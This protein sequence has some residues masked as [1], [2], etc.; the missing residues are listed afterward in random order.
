MAKQKNLLQEIESKMPQLS[1][2]QKLVAKFILDHYEKAAFST[3]LRM[4]QAVG[5]SESTVIR[6]SNS[7]GFEGYTELQKELQEL[8]K[9][10]LTTVQRIEVASDMLNG[11]DL[12]KSVLEADI[13]KIK[14]T[15]DTI[16]HEQ[17]DSAIKLLLEAKKIYIV[18]FRSSAPLGKFL[19]FYLNLILDN[20]IIIE[21]N[22]MG[23]VFEQIFKITP[24]DVMIGISYPRYSQRTLK[25][26]QYALNNG[27]KVISITDSQLSPLYNLGDAVLLAKSGMTFF[28][29]SLV[30]PLSIINAIIAAIGM[31]KKQQLSEK[32]EKLEEIW[33]EYN[34][35]QKDEE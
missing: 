8:I 11:E 35:Y 34:V 23:E 1:K 2:G 27:A 5:V 9:S 4:G 21:S 32:L 18:G 10:K 31:M 19:G 16:N 29:D 24:D 3:A 6:F 26:V 13:A 25:S 28:V 12:I 33:D 15:I 30:A 17:F 14:Y 22:A 7:I 20:V